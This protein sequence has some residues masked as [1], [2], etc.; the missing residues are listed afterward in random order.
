M[1]S[2]LIAEAIHLAGS[3]RKLEKLIKIPDISIH[4]YKNL[5]RKMTYSRFKL[6]LEYLGLDESLICFKLIDPK[7]FRRKGGKAVYKKY[8]EEN[9][10]FEI[11]EG[12]R[13]GASKFMKSW[14]LRMKEE[15]PSEYYDLQHRR[16]K[17][18][19]KTKWKTYKGDLVRN[20]F[21]MQIANLLFDLSIDYLYEPCLQLSRAYFPDFKI[22]DTLLECTAWR[23][24]EKA[25][26]LSLK[27]KAYE[28]AGF[29]VKV[30]IPK[31]LRGFYK[32]IENHIISPNDIESL[33]LGRGSSAGGASGC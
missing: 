17:K 26:Q 33:F 12:M 5:R 22:G 25:N 27:I 1:Q 2:T 29:R 9:R 20:E 30:V 10:F 8:F 3:E 13:R 32:P 28:E 19:N 21:E 18:V 23:G 7:E 24:K 4:E 14:H 31:N 11:H 16:F 6:L 15:N